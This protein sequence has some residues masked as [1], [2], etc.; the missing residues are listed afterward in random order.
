MKT[1][2]VLSTVAILLMALALSSCSPKTATDTF[3]NSINQ[4]RGK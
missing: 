4:E 2:E 3:Q 1:L